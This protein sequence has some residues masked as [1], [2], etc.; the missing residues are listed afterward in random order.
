MG[1]AITLAVHFQDMDVVSEVIEHRASE[2]F[3][4]EHAGPFIEWQVAGG[5]RRAALISLGEYLKRQ[6]G[7]VC[8]SVT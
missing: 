3:R 5:D 2:T 8:D 1:E 4:A 7:A 6:L